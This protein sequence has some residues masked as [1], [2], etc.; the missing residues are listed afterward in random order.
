MQGQGQKH[1]IKELTEFHNHLQ[2]LIM[3]TWKAYGKTVLYN[4]IE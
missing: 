2:A 1:E 3:M 4:S